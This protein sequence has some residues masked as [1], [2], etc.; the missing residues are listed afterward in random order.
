MTSIISASIF[1]KK[2]SSL[3]EKLKLTNDSIGISLITT[4]DEWG[5]TKQFLTNT[6]DIWNKKII[7]FNGFDN[8]PQ[9]STKYCDLSSS[10]SQIIDEKLLHH[11]FEQDNLGTWF[12]I[13]GDFSIE[14]DLIKESIKKMD[15][16]EP[17]SYWK[18]IDQIY[19]INEN[20]FN[21]SYNI[22]VKKLTYKDNNDEIN[23]QK[24]ND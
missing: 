12:F 2:N 5:K 1:N 16:D 18:I 9:E 15:N 24:R 19:K 17:I 22:I 14:L 11:F 8:I 20:E 6:N 13:G 3:S 10:S 7:F 21:N 23:K 4:P